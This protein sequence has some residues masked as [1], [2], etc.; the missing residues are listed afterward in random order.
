MLKSQKKDVIVH[1]LIPMPHNSN[2]LIVMDGETRGSVW[3]V[4]HLKLLR[5]LP[6][7]SG[8]V[9]EDGKL[10]LYAPNKGGLHVGYRNFKLFIEFK[11]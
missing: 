7:F 9:T 11:V 6:T 5:T 3:D 10:G 8:I 2:Q 1:K 4:R